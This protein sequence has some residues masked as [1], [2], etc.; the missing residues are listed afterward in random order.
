MTV[1]TTE[2]RISYS[3]NAVTTA[4]DFPY[5]F[6]ATS[7]LKVY[8]DDVLMVLT[9]DYSVGSPSDDGASVTFVVAPAIGSNNIVILRDPDLLQ[10]FDCREDVR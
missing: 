8:V 4:F 2:N 10:Q 7:D 5:K 6:L 1:S 3:G 9:T